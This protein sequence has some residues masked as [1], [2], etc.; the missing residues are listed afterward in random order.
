[1]RAADSMV[2]AMGR[3][4][5][6]AAAQ[7]NAADAALWRWFTAMLEDRRINGGTASATGL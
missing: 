5:I 7:A 2:D 1:M 4:R 6:E 3:A